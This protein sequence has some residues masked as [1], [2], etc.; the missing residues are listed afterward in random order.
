MICDPVLIICTPR[1]I[2][3][4]MDKMDAGRVM[5]AIQMLVLIALL[6]LTLVLILMAF[7]IRLSERCLSNRGVERGIFRVWV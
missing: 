5:R 7:M 4:E 3:D 1:E 2:A 6:T